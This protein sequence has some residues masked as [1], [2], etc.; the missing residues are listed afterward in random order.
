MKANSKLRQDSVQVRKAIIISLLLHGSLLFLAF[1][2]FM[3]PAKVKTTD[4]KSMAVEV[5]SASEF[6]QLK[7]GVK[8]AKSK[9][10]KKKNLPKKKKVVKAAPKPKKIVHAKVNKIVAK[11]AHAASAPK[12]EVKKTVK[13]QIEVKTEN[14][15]VDKVLTPKTPIVQKKV[16]VK[17]PKVKPAPKKAK[18][19]KV[20]VKKVVKKVKRK[21]KP[22]KKK[23]VRKKIQ[24]KKKAKRRTVK[25]KKKFNP[26]SIAAIL[27][28]IP[29]AGGSVMPD[30]ITKK[31][32]RR[33]LA[34]AQN[35]PVRGRRDGWANRVTASE[36]DFFRAQV[37]KCWSPPVGGL[38]SGHMIVKLRLK[39]EQDGSLRSMPR[40][41]NRQNSAVFNAAAD[42]AIRAVWQCQPYTMPRE[43]YAGDQGWNDMILNFNPSEMHSGY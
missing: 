14:K 33:R 27:N 20:V 29:D 24:K 38:G 9:A 22:R 25:R 6:T 10:A 13:K 34:S 2:A 40:L 8:H 39:F 43:K 42:S 11:A 16:K 23:V 3:A 35:A 18:A 5:L 26:D 1:G 41:L 17:K 37:S 28:K 19:K 7:A 32:K 15:A 30:K 4:A 21:R 31:T 36:I 12:P